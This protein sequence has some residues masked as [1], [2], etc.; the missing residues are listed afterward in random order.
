MKR[1][2]YIAALLL[3]ALLMA[4]TAQATDAGTGIFS[5]SATKKVQFA[6]ENETNASTQNLFQW[7]NIASLEHD[8]WRVLSYDEWTHLLVSSPTGRDN[9]DNLNALGTID[10]TH[11]LIILSDNFILPAGLSFTGNKADL[12]YNIYT[13]AQWAQMEAAGA[14]FLP[15]TGY[16]W[17]DGPTYKVADLTTEG[18]YWSN[19]EYD[20]DT[21]KAIR[22]QFHQSTI[23]NYQASPKTQYYAV[24]LVREVGVL[25]ENDEQD[26]FETKKAIADDY[27][28]ALI[29]RTLYKDGYFN[30]LCLPF[31]VPQISNSPL[32]G[33]TVYN[34]TGADVTGVTGDEELHLHLSRVTNDR[35][36]IGVPYLIQ[37][38]NTDEVLT[39]M[40]FENV[41]WDND[42]TADADPGDGSVNFHG[43]YYRKH[44]NG[45]TNPSAAHFN[46]FVGA[47]NTLYWPD[48]GNDNNAKMKGFRAYFYIT[49]G[50]G[51]SSAPV[52]CGMR[53]SFQI[54]NTEDAVTN[55]E[56]LFNQSRNGNQKYFQNGKIVLVIDGETYSIGGEKL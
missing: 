10:G 8:G 39:Y 27:N 19:S 56:E 16:G 31:S 51:P 36:E 41:A 24:R 15:F 48:D 7:A 46:F 4:G 25:D 29:N 1:N 5:V 9:A 49:P 47:E 37:W 55:L 22:I 34:F 30:T 3:P 42:T 43:F 33:A 2:Y 13:S 54:T 11:G 20:I 50:G 12:S 53:A 21:D 32:A 14:V 28:F 52:R 38:A 23:H 18:S 44:V 35:L 6:T 40:R 26:D 17:M 45:N